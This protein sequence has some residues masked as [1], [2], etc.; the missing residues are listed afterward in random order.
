MPSPVSNLE[1]RSFPPGRRPVAHRR[2]SVVWTNTLACPDSGPRHFSEKTGA[3]HR[4]F[5]GGPVVEKADSRRCSQ[6]SLNFD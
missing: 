1:N 3:L 4:A 5:P 2:A 6:P